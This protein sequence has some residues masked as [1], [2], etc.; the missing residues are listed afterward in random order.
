[1]LIDWHTHVQPSPQAAET[2]FGWIG[3]HDPPNRG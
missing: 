3:M 1:M 2:F